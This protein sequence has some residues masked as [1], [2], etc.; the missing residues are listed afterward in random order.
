MKDKKMKPGHKLACAFAAVYGGP[1]LFLL[2]IQQ[3]FWGALGIA[4]GYY[5]LNKF[6]VLKKNK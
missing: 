2:M 1:G 6:G 3:W 4:I 5:I